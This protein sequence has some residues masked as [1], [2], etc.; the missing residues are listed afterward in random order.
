VTSTLRIQASLLFPLFLTTVFVSSIRTSN[1]TQ[2]CS[3]EA[4]APETARIRARQ[5]QRLSHGSTRA[6]R[7]QAIPHARHPT[8][9]LSA[10]HTSGSFSRG[11][12]TAWRNCLGTEP[13]LFS[14]PP[15]RNRHVSRSPCAVVVGT[16]RLLPSRPRAAGWGRKRKD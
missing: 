8:A 15:G 2:P 13:P 1:G 6:T 12:A 5:R 11:H 7:S 16:G 4:G 3:L 9:G 10:R 14:G